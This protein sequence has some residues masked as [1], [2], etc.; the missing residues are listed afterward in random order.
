MKPIP[1]IINTET[2]K[3][4]TV[5]QFVMSCSDVCI[6]GEIEGNEPEPEMDVKGS[7]HSPQQQFV[8]TPQDVKKELDTIRVLIKGLYHCSEKD[9]ANERLTALEQ[10]SKDVFNESNNIITTVRAL[11]K[12]IA[13]FEQWRKDV[14][15]DL[16]KRVAELERRANDVAV[17]GNNILHRLV[18][19][20][21]TKDSVNLKYLFG[22]LDMIVKELGTQNKR[23]DALYHI[24]HRNEDIKKSNSQ[25]I[26]KRGRGRPRKLGE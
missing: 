18:V 5:E 20:E 15:G 22:E 14:D 26:V 23:L 3:V 4:Q 7:L 17:H 19:L 2:G 9:N 13:F 21:Q 6:V 10:W 12:K 1:V 16:V 24:E 25:T 11:E 8:G